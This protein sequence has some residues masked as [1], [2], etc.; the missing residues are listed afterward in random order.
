[1]I[2]IENREDQGFDSTP[3]RED[4]RRRGREQVVDHRGDL[5]TP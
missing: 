1:M 2:A 4:M 3:S 5:Q